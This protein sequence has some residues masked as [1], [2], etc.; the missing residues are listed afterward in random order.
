M[1]P[2][3][4]GLDPEPIASSIAA[5]FA[6]SRRGSSR[7]RNATPSSTKSWLARKPGFVRALRLAAPAMKEEFEH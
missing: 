4:W 7:K 2:T 5:I 1:Q 6:T 3:Y